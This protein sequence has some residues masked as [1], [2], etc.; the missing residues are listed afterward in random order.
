[1]STLALA[2]NLTR[3][4]F[5]VFP[6][7]IAPKKSIRSLLKVGNAV[8]K[9]RAFHS[10]LNR[11]KQ[12]P[13]AR[14]LIEARYSP[15]IPSVAKLLTYAPNTLGYALGNF[16][17]R[18][19]FTPYPTPDMATL[20][21][22]AYFRERWREIHDILHVVW[23]YETNLIGEA[24]INA[25]MAAQTSM[26]MCLLIPIGIIVK[27]MVS[28]PGELG[29]LME[30][31]SASWGKGKEST[32]PMGVRWESMLSMDLHEV[33]RAVGAMDTAPTPDKDPQTY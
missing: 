1:M 28:N 22:E 17:H 5:H 11:V 3:G 32:N 16:L 29:A 13:A 31:I 20:S 18:N 24:S 21:E 8:S 10:S 7:I 14:V 33:R 2:T 6:S 27:T 30:N 12:D 9:S 25:H 19:D 15:G 4:I 23:G 26:P